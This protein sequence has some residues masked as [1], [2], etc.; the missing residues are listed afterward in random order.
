[1][2][3]VTREGNNVVI[4]TVNENV[5]QEREDSLVTITSAQMYDS[6]ESAKKAQ[7]K[8]KELYEQSTGEVNFLQGVIDTYKIP[9]LEE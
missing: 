6:L 2:A 5:K 3:L 8:H 1:M 7:A 4:R 9:K